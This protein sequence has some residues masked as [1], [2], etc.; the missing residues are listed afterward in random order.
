VPQ[1]ADW[2][3][4]IVLS[5]FCTILTF[6]LYISALKKV[7]A[8]T[9]NLTLTLEPVYG[10]ILAFAIYRENKQLSNTFYIGFALILIAVMIQMGRIIRQHKKLAATAL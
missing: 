9:M 7:S 5:W 3:W 10:I 8:F 4:L 6:I 1:G 2:V